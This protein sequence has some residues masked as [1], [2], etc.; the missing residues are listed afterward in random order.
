MASASCCRRITFPTGFGRSSPNGKCI[1]DADLGEKWRNPVLALSTTNGR[2]GWVSRWDAK[3]NTFESGKREYGGIREY[4]LGEYERGVWTD[5]VVHAKWSYGSD[6]FLKIW[7]DGK[8]VIDQNGPNAYNDAS[9][10]FFKM[11]LYKGWGDPKKALR[12]RDQASALPRRIPHG[13]RRR[14]LSG[15]RPR[16]ALS[17]PCVDYPLRPCRRRDI[18]A[19]D[20]G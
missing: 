3:R 14:H 1:P 4:D 20:A 6:G 8:L 13:R 15:R 11:G 7:K 19:D 2:W 9:G 17:A 5:W 12:R 18:I 10:P 16:T